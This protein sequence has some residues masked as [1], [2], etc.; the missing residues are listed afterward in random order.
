MIP[1]V[2]IYCPTK[3]APLECDIRK[4]RFLDVPAMIACDILDFV[5]H[6]S[7]SLL[8]AVTDMGVS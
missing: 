6:G 5:V 7:S 4:G 8:V 1:L 3:T 2:C